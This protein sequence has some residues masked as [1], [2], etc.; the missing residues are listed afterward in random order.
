[1]A[2]DG[3]S[4]STGQI[5][6]S[7]VDPKVWDIDT[8]SLATCPHIKILLQDPHYFP[9]QPKYSLP[10]SSLLGLQPIITDLLHKG[11]LRPTHS[12]YN[13]PILAVKKE[14]LSFLGLAGYFHVW[15]PNY[16]LLAAPLYDATKG[17]PS[18]PLLTSVNTP[19]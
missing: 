10:T 8:L 11:L 16:S 5:L 12:P 2:T 18:E 1:M 6:P 3:P 4:D 7:E 19:F 9:C 13:S 14:I 17:D 15:I